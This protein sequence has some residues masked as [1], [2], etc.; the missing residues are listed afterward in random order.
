[1]NWLAHL[2]LSDPTPQFRVGNLLPDLISASQLVG[3][4]E[5]YQ[6]GI[7]Q[8]R[9]IDR[10]TDSHP[11]V[12]SCVERFPRPYR[13]Y[14]GILT[15]VYFDHFLA[16]DWSRYSTKPL[17]DFIADVH[18]DIE[19]CMADVPAAARYPL[20]RMRSDNWL[21]TYHEISGIADILA[22]ISTRFRRPFDLTGSVPIFEEHEPAF[23][24]DFHN[25]FPELIAHVRKP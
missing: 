20:D 1:V 4:A 23:A 6:A 18:R 9:E 7:R 14:A 13:R 15:D 11:R 24:E 8:H 10:F 22:R 21:G 3:M 12:K 5:T 19:I 2:Y 25:F 17:P 16:R